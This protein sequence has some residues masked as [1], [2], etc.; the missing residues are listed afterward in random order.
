MMIKGL[1]TAQMNQPGNI[2]LLI[3]VF[4]YPLSH[5]WS[6]RGIKALCSRGL[7]LEIFSDAPTVVAK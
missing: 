4:L 3:R 1:I 7:N 6:L 5:L 2:F